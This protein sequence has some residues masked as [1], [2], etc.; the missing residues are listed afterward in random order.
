MQLRACERRPAML[1]GRTIVRLLLKKTPVGYAAGVFY[2]PECSHLISS[3]LTA[4]LLV[5]YPPSM[6]I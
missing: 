3:Q 6:A 5:A 2:C 1:D 4:P